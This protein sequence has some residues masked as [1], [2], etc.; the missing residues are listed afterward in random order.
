MVNWDALNKIIAEG[1]ARE[2]HPP[3][4]HEEKDNYFGANVPRSWRDINKV[5]VICY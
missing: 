4:V 2:D 3:N 5:G 1:C